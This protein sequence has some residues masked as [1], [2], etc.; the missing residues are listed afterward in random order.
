MV[1]L[2]TP[3]R[4]TTELIF[5]DILEVIIDDERCLLKQR[6]RHNHHLIQR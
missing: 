5:I 3:V 2:G 4:L 1:S 6:C